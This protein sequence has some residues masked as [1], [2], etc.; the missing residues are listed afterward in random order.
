MFHVAYGRIFSFFI[1]VCVCVCVCVC[2]YTTFSLYIYPLMDTQVVSIFSISYVG[3]RSSLS[4]TYI[5]QNF[6]FLNMK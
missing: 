3:T 2:V 1:P 4:P 6:L 5:V